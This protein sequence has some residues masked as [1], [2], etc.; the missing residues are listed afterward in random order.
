MIVVLEG[1]GTGVEL[2]G[3]GQGKHVDVVVV[4]APALLMLLVTAS[5]LFEKLNLQF[6][7]VI[8]SIDQCSI[9]ESI[10]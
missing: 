8:Q 6:L 10:L 3:L 1:G 4:P 5:D 9:F 2:L 7:I